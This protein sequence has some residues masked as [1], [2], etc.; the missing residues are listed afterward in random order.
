MKSFK[1]FNEIDR[2]NASIYERLKKLSTIYAHSHGN[3]PFETL[4]QHSQLVIRYFISLVNK[5][6]LESIIDRLIRSISFDNDIIASYSK[7]LF[8]NTFLFHDLGK[9]NDNFQVEKMKNPN[10]EYDKSI[11]IGSDHSFLSAYAFLSFHI[12]EIYHNQS[13]KP[14]CKNI[15]ACYTFLFAVPIIKHHSGAILKDYEYM[16]ALSTSFLVMKTSFGSTLIIILKAK[17]STTFP[18][19]RCLNSTGRY[20]LPQTIM[21][22]QNI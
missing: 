16:K 20:L 10:L 21:P 17:T 11:K 8:F 15:L 18:F 6:S 5:H 19:S 9:A 12:H 3:K 22:L 14:D 2:G 7:K 13:I 4:S 1:S